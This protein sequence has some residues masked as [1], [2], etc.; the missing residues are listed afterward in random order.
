MTER[1]GITE[2]R[3]SFSEAIVFASAS[4]T[5]GGTPIFTWKPGATA[6][7]GNLLLLLD[8]QSRERGRKRETVQFLRH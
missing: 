2:D 6:S 3:A 5:R 1:R 7:M 8:E 4:I